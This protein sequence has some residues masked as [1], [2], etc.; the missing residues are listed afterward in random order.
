MVSCRAPQ[1]TLQSITE[2]QST[3]CRAPE[4]TLQSM[5]VDPR[6]HLGLAYAEA[7]R[8]A[9]LNGDRREDW[10]GEAYILLERAARKFDPDRGCQ[11]STYAT[12]VLRYELPKSLMRGMGLSRTFTNGEVAWNG[13]RPG[14]FDDRYMGGR[15]DH[16]SEGEGL[17]LE[18]CVG[19]EFEVA[20]MLGG[21]CNLPQAG[22][23]LGLSRERVRQIKNKAGKRMGVTAEPPQSPARGRAA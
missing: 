5:A 7:G 3:L 2:P 14:A 4:H 10:L 11:F 12:K 17:S 9:A 16:R 21:G 18:A 13:I 15:E 19:R 6:E 22:V 23:A 8:F 20:R 1:H